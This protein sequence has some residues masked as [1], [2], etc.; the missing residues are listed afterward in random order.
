MSGAIGKTPTP[1][2]RLFWSKIKRH[3]EAPVWKRVMSSITESV[4]RWISKQR[5]STGYR[6]KVERTLWTLPRE[7]ESEGR[8]LQHQS[9]ALFKLDCAP[10]P[11]ESWRS[12][13]S[14]TISGSLSPERGVFARSYFRYTPSRRL[15]E[16][17]VS[18]CDPQLR[19]PET[20]IPFPIRGTNPRVCKSSRETIALSAILAVFTRSRR[21]W[22]DVPSRVAK[23][24]SESETKKK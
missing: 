9:E 23:K 11:H 19:T 16:L 14:L 6:P 12:H 22:W 13:A 17:P 7:R 20:S 15:F 4:C 8:T 3:P 2:A 5:K 21:S 1:G 24:P 18:I 10:G